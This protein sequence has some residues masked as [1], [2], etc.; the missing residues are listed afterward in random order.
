MERGAGEFGSGMVGETRLALSG[1]GR[2]CIGPTFGPLGATCIRIWAR[3]IRLR[4]GFNIFPF[5]FREW[6]VASGRGG[7]CGKVACWRCRNAVVGIGSY[8]A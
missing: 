1:N 3:F 2:L 4:A 7:Q 8:L 6:S 5:L